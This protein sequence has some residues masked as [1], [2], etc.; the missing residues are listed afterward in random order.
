[1]TL[2]KTAFFG[3]LSAVAWFSPSPLPAAGAGEDLFRIHC[4]PCH[5]IAGTGGRGPSLA[6]RRLSHAPDDA[7]LSAL[8]A[9]GI[10]GS[11]MP[12]TRMTADENRQ[13]VAFVRSLYRPG[14][15]QTPGGPRGDRANGERLFWSKGNCGQ[16]HTAGA[17]G[18]HLGPDL[19]EVGARRGE[20]YLRT[21]L[22]TP[23]KE[24]PDTFVVYRRVIYMPDNFLEVRV[25]TRDGTR[26]TGVR[27]NE[28]TF[29]IQLRD[30]AD[31]LYSFR[32]D[33]LQE[34]DKDWG[35]SPMPAYGALLSESEIRDLVAYLM[36]LQGAP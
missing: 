19:T 3:I 22:L 5:G 9:A 13:L 10:P 15:A 1:M 25:V 11:E 31:R 32:K 2:G 35:K 29:T 17:R 18:G 6:V 24:L 23:E 26:I 16:C 14:A 20:D 12:G 28:D 36:S 34:L 33:E 8:I 30:F 4:A 27:V 7:A 21:V